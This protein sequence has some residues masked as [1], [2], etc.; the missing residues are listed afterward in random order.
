MI[1]DIESKISEKLKALPFERVVLWNGDDMEGLLRTLTEPSAVLK[2][3]GETGQAE[4]RRIKR[5]VD[6]ALYIV[7]LKVANSE[8]E[9]LRAFELIDGVLTALEGTAL[10][11]YIIREFGS[12]ERRIFRKIT[13]TF[14][15]G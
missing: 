11:K 13:L 6:F 4:N 10:L 15:G 2:Y 12:D 5:Q 14:L 8:K 3:E 9:R 1:A 7:T